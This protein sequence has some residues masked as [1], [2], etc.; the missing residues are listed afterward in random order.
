M[1]YVTG[2][3]RHPVLKVLKVLLVILVIAAAAGGYLYLHPDLWRDWVKGTPLEPAP[4]MTRVY[5]WKDANG[6]WQIS[7]R[8]PE[9]GINYETM[10]YREDENVVPSLPVEEETK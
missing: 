3:A 2:R 5:K 7:D 4:A 1:S 6:Q 8:P 9:A 10:Q